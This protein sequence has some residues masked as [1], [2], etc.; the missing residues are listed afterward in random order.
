MLR[1]AYKQS[2]EY[3]SSNVNFIFIKFF[4]SVKFRLQTLNSYYLGLF[5]IK[6]VYVIFA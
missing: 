2:L 5:R 3:Y 4:L 1:Y 6:H